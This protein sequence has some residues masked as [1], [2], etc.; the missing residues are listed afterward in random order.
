MR[1]GSFEC[2]CTMFPIAAL[3]FSVVSVGRW[4]HA[5]P[6]PL[7]RRFFRVWLPLG[8]CS[9]CGLEP[10]I[11]NIHHTCETLT[12]QTSA[13]IS[14]DVRQARYKSPSDESVQLFPTKAPLGPCTETVQTELTIRE[15]AELERDNGLILN[16]NRA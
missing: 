14:L 5:L 13:D 11:R 8:S 15:Q 2:L 4:R 7:V 16:P 3:S 12:L 9:C 1:A 10:S 6:K